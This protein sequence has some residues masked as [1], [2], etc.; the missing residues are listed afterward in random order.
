MNPVIDV[1][2]TTVDRKRRKWRQPQ[3][4]DEND[5]V[6]GTCDEFHANFVVGE[7]LGVGGNGAVYAATTVRGRRRVLDDGGSGD[8]DD[9]GETPVA[10][11]F[12]ERHKSNWTR[13]PNGRSVPVEY[14]AMRRLEHVDGV[15][16]AFRY[17]D[18]DY[19]GDV[20][21][22]VMERPAGNVVDLQRYLDERRRLRGRPLA[23][24]VAKQIFRNVLLTVSDVHDAGVDHCD[25]KPAN[26]LVD[27]DT[28]CV[29]LIDFGSARLLRDDVA[30]TA[31]VGTPYYFPP[32]CWLGEPYLPRPAAV[33]SLGV[34]LY[35]ILYTGVGG[36]GSGGRGDSEPF[37]TH[38]DRLAARVRFPVCLDVTPSPIA[39]CLVRECLTLN[40]VD[41]PTIDEILRHPYMKPNFALRQRAE[42]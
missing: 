27:V 25:L 39:E 24:L 4:D 20:V 41:R 28:L 21:A 8:D 22:I 31:R 12:V 36:D 17:F 34:V 42:S 26:I 38:E 11:K 13:R 10:V 23:P 37:A 19:S 1:K 29:R 30:S 7:R 3:N 18:A 5:D 16:R 14:H 32:E 6:C 40:P 33:W 35:Q 2:T 15:V 9:D